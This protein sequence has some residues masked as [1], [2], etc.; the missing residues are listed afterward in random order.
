MSLSDLRKMGL[1]KAESAWSSRIPRSSVP[2]VL[3][4]VCLVAAVAGCTMMVLGDGGAMTW[5]G[6]AI[7]GAG[8][9]V[10]TWLNVRSVRADGL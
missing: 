8:L 10:F 4:G 5:V 7:F 9:G 3:A 1:L 6:L 2:A